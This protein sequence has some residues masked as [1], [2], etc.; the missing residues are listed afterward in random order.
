M[1][2]LFWTAQSLFAAYPRE[3]PI[4]LGLLGFKKDEIIRLREGGMVTHSILDKAPGEF[5]I[6]AARVFNVPVYYFRDYYG[7]IENYRNLFQ[8]E[9]VGKFKQA[10]DLMDLKALRFSDGEIDEFL[11]CKVRDCEMKLS[12]EEIALIPGSPD[13]KTDAGKEAVSDVYRSIL[14]N[15]LLAYKKE[16]MAGLGTYED[17]PYLYDPK[18]I[19]EAHLLKFGYLDAYFPGVNRYLL[20]YPNYKDPKIVDFF[21]WSRENL[22]NK[23]V[24]TIRHVITRRVGEDYLMINRLV[25]SNHYFLSSMAVM[26]LINYADAVSPWTLFVFQQRTLTDLHGPFEGIG[27]NILRSNLEKMVAS[28]IKTTGKEMEERYKS[29]AFA[30]FP[31]GLL[32]RDQQ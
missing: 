24:V 29:K 12:A 31:F 13:N 4:Y 9:S 19:S 30:K 20:E 6:T 28:E 10:P 23:P 2:L 27:R 7:Y 26:H 11:S 32:P 18:A 17:G 22:G 5:G 1:I 14:L 25:Y 15:R 3:Y 16:G 8:F 21:Y